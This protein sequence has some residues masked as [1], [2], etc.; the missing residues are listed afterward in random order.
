MMQ[1]RAL[2]HRGSAG[3]G[4]QNAGRGDGSERLPPQ[5]HKQTVWIRNHQNWHSHCFI[6]GKAI[7]GEKL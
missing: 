1:A 5:R 6:D 2:L 7:S 4:W 3:N